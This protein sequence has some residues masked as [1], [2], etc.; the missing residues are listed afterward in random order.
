MYTLYQMADR[1]LRQECLNL[2][3]HIEGLLPGWL[4]DDSHTVSLDDPAYQ[5]VTDAVRLTTAA[6][7]W[8]RWHSTLNDRC[9]LLRISRDGKKSGALNPIHAGAWLLHGAQIYDVSEIAHPVEDHIGGDLCHTVPASDWLESISG[10]LDLP[11]EGCLFLSRKPVSRLNNSIHGAYVTWSRGEDG[12]VITIT[13]EMSGEQ[14]GRFVGKQMSYTIKENA[15]GP[16]LVGYTSDDYLTGLD[17]RGVDADR[18]WLK[19]PQLID[20]EYGSTDVVNRANEVQGM[21]QVIEV[22]MSY[23][24]WLFYMLQNRVI[25]WSERRPAKKRKGQ[26]GRRSGGGPLSPKVRTCKLDTKRMARIEKKRSGK[27]PDRS[28]A[29]TGTPRGAYDG[30]AYRVDRY[31]RDIWVKEKNVLPGEEWKDIKQSRRGSGC[32]VLVHRVCN[33][34]GYVIGDKTAVN[35][36]RATPATMG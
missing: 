18:K 7:S 16:G 23:Y 35:L 24:L 28:N 29:G 2:A 26:R 30:P 25:V 21:A 36:V 20:F 9:G 32:L 8:E 6:F 10:L 14:K 33:E 11:K 34:S 1:K 5:S 31:E 22:N 27:K 12:L 17:E 13:S 3:L 4:C 15:L 19:L